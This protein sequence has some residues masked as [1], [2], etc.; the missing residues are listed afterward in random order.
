M[1]FFEDNPLTGYKNYWSDTVQSDLQRK[2][3]ILCETATRVIERCILMATDPGDLVLDPP[4]V[5]ARRDCGGAMGSALDNNRH[6]PRRPGARPH[7]PMS[8]RYPYY[9]LADSPEAVPKSRQSRGA[10]RR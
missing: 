1:R 6:K 8:A 10:R 5:P 3:V 9:L 4:A 2:N 7:A